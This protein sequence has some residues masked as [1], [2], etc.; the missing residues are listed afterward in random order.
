V[1]YLSGI[2]A[3]HLDFSRD[4][5]WVTYVAHPEATLWRSKVDGTERLQLTSAPMRAAEPVWSP[6]GKWIA[7]MGSEPGRPWK[8]CLVS[9]EGGTPQRLMPGERNEGNPGWS[10]DGTRLVFGRLPW[11][12]GGTA[13]AAAIHVLDLKTKEVSTL[14]GS[15]GL[16]SPRWSP[17][18]RYVAAVTSGQ[19]WTQ[20]LFDFT[21]LKWTELTKIDG[22]FN[23]WSRDGKYVYFEKPES[24]LALFRVRV[25]DRHLE[26]I[27][28]PQNVRRALGVEGA[29]VGLA[30]D[31]SVLITRDV[32]IQEIYA[33]DWEA[34]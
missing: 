11:M 14:P 4:G 13:G 32:G 23:R 21:V 16:M 2:S 31:D 5:Q 7:F 29:W 1:P 3:E 10:P 28:A 22:C 25:S 8:I 15:E 33:L 27:L 18:G 30:L 20:V 34:P 24:R 9:A 26:E 12:E 17:D 19:N 6:D